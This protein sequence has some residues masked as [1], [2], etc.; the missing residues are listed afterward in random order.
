MT[1][2]GE[3]L[4][5]LHCFAPVAAA[6][7]RILILGSMPGKASLDAVEYYAHPRNIF[8]RI[9][10]ELTGAGRELAY[11]HRLQ[12][13]QTAGIALWDVLESCER[14]GSLDADIHGDSMRANDF[15]NFFRA[16]PQLQRVLFNG[17]TAATTF[18]RLVRP[19]LSTTTLQFQRLPST[20]PANAAIS[21]ERKLEA[22]RQALAGGERT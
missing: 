13:L 20:S 21:Y 5:R 2:P 7:A 8:W 6:D 3:S 18:D 19:G 17:A 16:H 1:L 9:L 10:G 14:R 12:K 4:P 22:W 11:E 15:A